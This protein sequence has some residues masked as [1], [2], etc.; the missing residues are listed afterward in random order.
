MSKGGREILIKAVAQAIRTYTMACFDI[1]K[2][3][4]TALVAPFVC[5]SGTNM[6][7]SI[8]CT[9]LARTK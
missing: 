4:V 1:T 5:I 6:I 7:R 9:G 2:P 8:E 3:C